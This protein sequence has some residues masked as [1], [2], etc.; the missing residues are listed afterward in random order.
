VTFDFPWYDLLRDLPEVSRGWI[1]RCRQT[2]CPTALDE[3]DLPLT[4]SSLRASIEYFTHQRRHGEIPKEDAHQF[5]IC[6]ILFCQCVS[7]MLK[8]G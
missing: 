6:A 1:Q 7:R 4:C 3:M 5:D 8:H 2:G